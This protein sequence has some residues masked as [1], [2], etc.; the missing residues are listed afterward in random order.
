M[1]YQYNANESVGFVQEITGSA[2]ITRQDGSSEPLT[3]GAEIFQGDVIQTSENGAVN[4]SFT[5]ET[6]FAISENSHLTIDEY[7]YDPA[8]ESGVTD[9]SVLQ[10]VFV[11]TSGAIGR[12]DP[13]DV[14]INTPRGSIGIRGTIIAGDADNGE[15]TVVE[16]AIVLR[17]FNGNEVTLANQFESARFAPD[18]GTIEDM[19]VL[20]ASEV[21]QKFVSVSGVSPTLFSSIED[22]AA[23][24]AEQGAEQQDQ[25][26]EQAGDEPS[27]G[28]EARGEETQGE[29]PA[30]DN[31]EALAEPAAEEVIDDAQEEARDEVAEE[32]AEEARDEVAEEVAEEARDEVAKEVAEEAREEV[33]QEAGEKAEAQPDTTQQAEAA[34]DVQ[35]AKPA[36]EAKPSDTEPADAQDA[37]PAQDRANGKAKG[38]KRGEGDSA[39]AERGERGESGESREGKGDGKPTIQKQAIADDIEVANKP[40]QDMRPGGNDKPLADV[41]PDIFGKLLKPGLKGALSRVGIGKFKNQTPLMQTEDE[42]GA[43]PNVIAGAT[44]HSIVTAEPAGE[45]HINFAHVFADGDTPLGDLT[46]KLEQS[47]ENKLSQ[48][49]N[50]NI[51][52][53][54]QFDRDTGHMMLDFDDASVFAYSGIDFQGP[55]EITVKAY[56]DKGAGQSFTVT[57]DKV[58]AYYHFTDDNYTG[59]VD[60]TSSELKLVG[61]AISS[62]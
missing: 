35:E 45:W 33:A 5:D 19:G 51:L 44:E 49:K 21:G 56:D 39:D 31:S 52:N 24:Q 47:S 9:F 53:D 8:T 46:F 2:T 12:D 14:T 28:E 60:A 38:E 7:V 55:L 18:G 15:I 58:D 3:M 6:Q 43:A 41:M 48:L 16:G 25:Q 1:S 62:T 54:V 17:D 13:D 32:V 36:T 23:E 59:F 40:A 20:K 27:E 11:Y 34:S 50:L 22:A 57:L 4:L 42:R 37:K 10:G 61:R 26:D 30:A 29:E